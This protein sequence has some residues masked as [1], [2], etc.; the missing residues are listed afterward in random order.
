MYDLIFDPGHGGRDPGAV[1]PTRYEKDLN[2]TLAQKTAVILVASGKYNVRFTRDVDK[3]FCGYYFNVDADLVNRVDIANQMSGS[4]FVSFHINSAN[5]EAHGNEVYAWQPGGPA[6]KLAKAIN[7]RMA[8]Q[9]DM[10]DRGVKFAN[11]YVC[12][13]TDMPASLVEYGFINS[14][15]DVIM[16][17]MDQAALAIAQGI[18]D[19]FGVSLTIEEEEEDDVLEYAILM[20]TDEDYWSAKDV[21]AK[22]GGIAMF[23]RQGQDKTIPADAMKAKQLITI[24]GPVTGHTNEILLSGKDKYQTADAVRNYLAK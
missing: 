23:V 3:D 12:R 22:G 2:L 21:S 19:Y 10:V 16:A 7:T 11:W 14:E 5:A 15:E 4:V 1:G 20:F 24:G 17:K 6:E 9:L 13:K 8:A 18:A